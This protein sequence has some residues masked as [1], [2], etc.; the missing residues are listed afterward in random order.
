MYFVYAIKNTPTGKIYIGQTSDLNTRL[1]FHNK[2]QIGKKNAYTQKYKGS[3]VLIYKELVSDRKT[4][5]IRERQLKSA[6]G[7]EFIKHLPS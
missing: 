2:I 4:A 7:R 5:L 3:W 6:K 1:Q